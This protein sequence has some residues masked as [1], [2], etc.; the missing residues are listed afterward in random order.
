MK[1]AK[2]AVLHKPDRNFRVIKRVINGAEILLFR[3]LAGIKE[4]RI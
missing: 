1:L 2:T 3:L 4:Y